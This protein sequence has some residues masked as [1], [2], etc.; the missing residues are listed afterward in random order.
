L[1]VSSIFQLL[2]LNNNLVY[3]IVSKETSGIIDLSG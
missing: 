2:T 1:V 3:L